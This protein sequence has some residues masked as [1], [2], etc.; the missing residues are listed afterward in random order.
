MI[1]GE[2]VQFLARFGDGDGVCERDSNLIVG[3]GF[4]LMAQGQVGQTTTEVEIRL[5]LL[6][7]S[8]AVV[9]HGGGVF[10]AGE[11]ELAQ[12]GVGVGMIGGQGA[13]LLAVPLRLVQ[14]MEMDE[15][16][17]TVTMAHGLVMRWKILDL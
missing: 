12:A 13:R 11:S 15:G 1:G 2:F 5:W 4:V 14:A 17:C 7:N 9:F 3:Q 16:V 6:I 10:F 8:G